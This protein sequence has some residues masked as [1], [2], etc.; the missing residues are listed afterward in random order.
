MKTAKATDVKKGI[1]V[2]WETLQCPICLDLMTAPLTTKCGH[3]FCKFC[4]MKLLDNSKQNRA[5]CPVC[6]TKITKRS[7]QE[8]PG[9][10][11]LVAGLQ[12]IIQ[13][14]E[15]D[16]GTSYFSGMALERKQ[17]DGTDNETAEHPHNMSSG[18]TAVTDFDNM[19]NP[20]HDDLP[21]SPS[22]TIAAQNGF[23]RLMGLEGS[24]PL[25]AENERLDS[26]LGDVP[27]TSDK[28]DVSL[29]SS[30]ILQETEHKN[31]RK[32]SRKKQ[33]KDLEPDK[34]LDKKQ[35]K[36]LE[37]VAEWLMKV[38][39]EGSLELEKPDEDADDSC[40]STSTIDIQQHIS[41]MNPKREDRA[42]A[43]EEQVFGAVYKRDR[44]GN[45]NGAIPTTRKHETSTEDTNE[46][47]SGEESS[48]DIFKEAE[49]MEVME[50]SNVD[51]SQEK[52]DNLP[53]NDKNKGRDEVSSCGSNTEQQQLKKSKRKLRS[54]LQQ[55]DSDLQEQPEAK[56][57][58]TEQNKTGKSK[59]KNT[60]RPR[61]GNPAKV[62]K[63][64]VLVE[65]Q[66]G[67]TSPKTR[68]RSEVQVQ[69]EN[70]P[71]SGDQ[72]TP[73]RKSTGRRRSLRLFV[74][75][76]QKGHKNAKLKTT[77]GEKG[78]NAAKQWEGIKGGVLDN[79]AS[80]E[81]GD[82][83]KVFERNG[84]VYHQELEGI[85]DMEPGEGTSYLTPNDNVKEV[86]AEV[87]NACTL[88]E[89]S[90]ACLVPVVPSSTESAVV[91]QAVKSDKP[92]NLFSE[93][94]DM[95]IATECPLT[96]N[97]KDMND[98]EAD[99]E[100]LLRSFKSIKRKS[101]YLGG[102]NLKRHCSLEQEDAHGAEAEENDSVC[103]GVEAAE[104]QSDT[105]APEEQEALRDNEHSSCC[106]LIPPTLSPTQ[107]QKTLV[108]KP[109]QVVLESSITNTHTSQESA[110]A[111]CHSRS[112]INSALSPN[113]VSKHEITPQ[114]SVVPQLVDSGHCF[115]V[116]EREELNKSSKCSQISNSQLECTISDAGKLKGVGD[117]VC[118]GKNSVNTAEGTLLAESSLTPD[119]LMS[120][121]V[122]MAH[123][124]RPNSSGS[125]ELSAHSSIKSNSRKKRKVQ[126][127]ESSSDSDSNGSK[128]ELPTLTQIFG[129]SALQGTVTEDQGDCS[130]GNRCEPACKADAAEQLSRSPACSSPDC[131]NSSQASVDLFGTPDECDVPENNTGV[132]IE[133]SQFSSEVLVTQ[134]KIEMQKELVRLEKLMALVSEVLHEKECS[135]AKEVPPEINQSGVIAVA[136]THK[137]LQGQ[138]HV[139]QDL[140]QRDVPEA[141]KQL[142]SSEGK[143]VVQPSASKHGSIADM[144]VQHSTHTALNVRGAEASKTPGSSSATRTLKKCSPPTDGQEDK[145]NNTPSIDR[146]KT[147]LVLVSSGLGLN[148]QIMVKKF[149]KRVGAHVV[150]QVTPEVTHIVMRTDEQLVC[151]RTLKYFLGIAGRKW[152]VSFQWISECFKQKKLLDESLF[153]VKGDVVNGPNH[154]GPSKA[155][156]TED[157][158][159]LLR[160]YKICFQGPFTD[161]TTDEMGWMVELCGAAV[162]KDPF[163]FDSEQRSHHL[164]VVQPGSESSSSTYS[165]LSRQATVVT[166]GW[167]LDTVATYTLQNYNNYST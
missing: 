13:A 51:K 114:H 151:E 135:P 2:L 156:N 78:S 26:G 160:G 14:Y 157:N 41:D 75:E 90:A 3:Q 23:A 131:V 66:D 144:T 82:T 166:R 21:R 67:E 22:S 105:K 45:R 102:P 58:S 72:E 19:E 60:K 127:L 143:V 73:L 121:A 62:P 141:V 140:D 124:T 85:E 64:L 150:S 120:P 31:L 117:S 158:N 29:I 91:D 8:S 148:E 52:L 159:L 61:K 130:D 49:K 136:D 129:I 162:I 96:E 119:G 76:I 81:N 34:I 42:K 69:I 89:A 55:V 46:S 107:A 106:D 146:R 137:P 77:V 10:Q 7:L 44:R 17:S 12:N 133:S 68:L 98:S 92:A 37:K 48:R 87:P 118:T 84:C 33:N 142:R 80:P 35:K 32:S 65:V 63:P 139:G 57:K 38:P 116:I 11:R 109:N 5:S 145:E 152:V 70:Y 71:S 79:T 86:A 88:L 132:S 83:T 50:E 104:Q 95:E 100:Q 9:F 103:S 111:E 134:Q 47:N 59:G 161:M 128:E 30:A 18:D 99:T 149:A 138:Q 112:T 24:T 15:H 25:T 164:I 122:Q 101:F 74:E 155:R 154:Q 93:N 1:S 16:T 56:S 28:N 115:K 53:G 4:I 108:E 163:H 97:V 43:L 36:S 167:L 20:N 123:E 153:E 113:K 125:A 40:S 39:T 94:L 27:P 54:A 147:K 110:G 6:K 126:R 165:S